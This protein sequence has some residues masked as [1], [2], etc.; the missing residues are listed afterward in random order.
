ME[1][2]INKIYQSLKKKYLM[3]YLLASFVDWI[4]GPYLY[5]LYLH[6]DYTTTDIS[7]FYI[8]GFLSSA[9]SGVLIGHL[10]DKFGRKKLCVF[11][12]ISTIIAC[13]STTSPDFTI[14]HI[15]RIFGGISTSI[16]FS[17]FESWYVSRHMSEDLPQDW[18][19][20]T[21]ASSTLYNGLLAI[22]AGILSSILADTFDYGPVSPFLFAIPVCI[23]TGLLCAT[24]WRE[25]TK[26]KVYSNFL[27]GLSVIFRNDGLLFYL[28]LIQTLFETVMYIFVFLWTPILDPIEPSNGLIF[29]LF[30]LCIVFGS[31]LHSLLANYYQI[32][33]LMLLCSS[34]LLALFS[35]AVSTIGIHLQ[36]QFDCEKMGTYVCLI[37]FL[38][39]ELSVGIY[40]PAVGYLRG[41]IVPEIH[42]ASV[43]N[44]FR[45]P[46]NLLICVVLLY[47]R[48]GVPDN[49]LIFALSAMCLS[50]ASLYCVEFVKA[51]K[52]EYSI[53][54]EERCSNQTCS[55]VLYA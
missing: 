53:I 40:Y 47:V 20:S 13:L 42:R 7:I 11:Y 14:L 44:W 19:G 21:F 39:F 30:M 26:K 15:G 6:Y 22:T 23:L 36:M 49:R 16:L 34:V 24:I 12:F 18:M 37:S 54:N 8:T 51:Y 29:S 43:A 45:L 5:K 2:D 25:N 33:R 9:I 1:I 31:A 52:R 4:Q 35:I 46:S 28:G 50:I 32:T 10:A 41:I 3:V 27:Q 55:K 48:I 38:T 17:S